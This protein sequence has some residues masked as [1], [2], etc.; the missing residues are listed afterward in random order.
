MSRYVEV[1]LTCTLCGV[2]SDPIEGR[3]IDRHEWHDAPSD[4]LEITTPPNWVMDLD[5]FGDGMGFVLCPEHYAQV[6]TLREASA[7]AWRDRVNG[8]VRR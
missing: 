7:Q 6:P 1:T 4:G 2:R 8:G 3:S 5:P